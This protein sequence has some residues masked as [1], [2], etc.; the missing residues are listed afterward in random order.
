MDV[1][2]FSPPFWFLF[3]GSL[4]TYI[5]IPHTYAACV[6]LHRVLGVLHRVVGL[7]GAHTC[8]HGSSYVLVSPY[9]SPYLH[10][11][12]HLVLPRDSHQM[13]HCGPAC[14]GETRGD[15]RERGEKEGRKRRGE[16]GAF[17]R[18]ASEPSFEVHC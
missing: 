3:E 9:S 4:K 7:L 1:F 17:Q 11:Y 14:G 12:L 10:V 8:W 2:D 18:S 13:T 15:E 6:I 16:G 5:L